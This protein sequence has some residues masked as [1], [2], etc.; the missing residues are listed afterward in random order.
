[1]EENDR[2]RSMAHPAAMIGSDG[3]A[4]MQTPHPRLWGSFPRVLG[5]YVREKKLFELETAVHKMTG[6]TASRFGLENRGSIAIGNYA[7]LVLFDPDTVIDR[8]SFEDPAQISDGIISVWVN[9]KLS[10]HE[11]Q[12]TGTRNG[13][14]LTH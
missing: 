2:Q 3:I 13:R 10:W 4:S 12:S 7:D 14:F 9:G 11:Q 5:H 8:A 6:L 1:M